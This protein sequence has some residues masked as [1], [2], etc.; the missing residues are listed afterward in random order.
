MAAG[1]MSLEGMVVVMMGV[2]GDG[3]RS[4]RGERLLVRVRVRVG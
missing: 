4:R 1:R 2:V 3:L